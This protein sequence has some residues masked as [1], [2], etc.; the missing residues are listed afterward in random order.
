V[1][2]THV[3][4][5]VDLLFVWFFRL[6]SIGL[7]NLKYFLCSFFNS[8]FCLF[9]D[10]IIFRNSIWYTFGQILIIKVE[11]V[12]KFQVQRETRFNRSYVT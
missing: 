11:I 4:D 12:L 9:V 8:R 7:L 3:L 5:I 1:V 10:K 2:D 6:T